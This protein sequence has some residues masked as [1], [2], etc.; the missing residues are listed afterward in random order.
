[1][2]FAVDV[3][4]LL[5]ASDTASRFH[6][7]AAEFLESVAG[8]T[9]IVCLAWSTAMA[10]LRIATHPAIFRTPLSPAEAAGNLE[11]LLRLPHVRL[12]AEED[13]FWGVYRDVTRGVAVRGN[14][15]PDAQL[16]AVLRQH[17][18][19]RLYTNDAD[20]RKFPSLE[21]QNPLL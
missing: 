6:R 19:R 20:F 8:G 9:E 4:V 13:G 14:L 18:V 10:Y 17:G 21:V 12:L 2:S 11:R 5:Y 3:N 7:R 1:V 16:A 15:V